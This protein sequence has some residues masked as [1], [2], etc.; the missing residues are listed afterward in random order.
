MPLNYKTA[1]FNHK[2]LTPQSQLQFFVLGL[3][4]WPTKSA[5]S[6]KLYHHTHQNPYNS[7]KQKSLT[8]KR[9]IKYFNTPWSYL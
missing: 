4:F 6:S 3:T 8:L 2:A 9:I 7:W 5:L 1:H